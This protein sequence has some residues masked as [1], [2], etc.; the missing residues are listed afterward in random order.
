MDASTAHAWILLAVPT[1]RVGIGEVSM[2][3]SML[4]N[5]EPTE[6]TLQESLQWLIAAGLI[7]VDGEFFMRTSA[8]DQI[9]EEEWNPE[10]MMDTWSAI[11]R[12]LA[13]IT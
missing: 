3:A 9:L 13:K 11:G 12:R 5:G 10:S 8:G 4:N 6:L 1:R 2:R 7:S